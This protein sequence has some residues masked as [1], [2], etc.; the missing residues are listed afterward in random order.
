MLVDF[1]LVN[2]FSLCIIYGYFGYLFC[3]YGWLGW[4]SLSM[5]WVLLVSGLLFKCV[6]VLVR[7]VMVLY[8]KV[9][10]G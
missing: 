4:F 1:L 10:C 2:G 9:F 8:W 6:Y 5:W 3:S 7:V